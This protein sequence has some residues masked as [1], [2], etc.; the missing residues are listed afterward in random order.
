MSL[1]LYTIEEKLGVMHS[2]ITDARH[3]RNE[4][5]QSMSRRRYE[6]LKSIAADLRAR[7][8]FARSDALDDMT[9]TLELVV[10]SKDESG[11]YSE[12]RLITAANMLIIRWPAVSQALQ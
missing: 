2:L 10:E 5:P 8:E 4:S 1:K 6:I 3:A 11:R 12:K 9:R 7:V